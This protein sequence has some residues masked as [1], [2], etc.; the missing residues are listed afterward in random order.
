M[1]G[2]VMRREKQNTSATVRSADHFVR[3][4]D[5]TEIPTQLRARMK[6]SVESVFDDVPVHYNLD[7]P[8]RLGALSYTQEMHSGGVERSMDVG[9]GHQ[10]NE[11]SAGKRVAII[12]QMRNNVVQRCGSDKGDSNPS[13][14]GAI[15]DG[16]PRTNHKVVSDKSS[17]PATRQPPNSSADLLKKDG[18]V[19]QRRYYD[20][21]GRAEMDIDFDHTD[22][23]T[24]KFPHIHLWDWNKEPPRQDSRR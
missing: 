11:S 20:E 9:R 7:M 5:C 4:R 1:L 6:Q 8:S 17:L 23:N 19:K 2:I 12:Q 10:A 24:H 14:E 3:K 22:D 15:N 18:S 21:D 13:I 16:Q